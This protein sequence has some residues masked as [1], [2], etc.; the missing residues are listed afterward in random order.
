MVE[1]ECKRCKKIFNKK[2]SYLT[3]FNRKIKCKIIKQEIHD[4]IIKLTEENNKINLENINLLEQNELLKIENN[5]LVEQNK[6][7]NKINQNNIFLIE[8]NNNL[9]KIMSNMQLL[10]NNDEL[11]NGGAIEGLQFEN[12]L[13]NKLKKYNVNVYFNK[14]ITK[15]YGKSCAGVNIIVKKDDK[16]I[17][18]Q[19]KKKIKSGSLKD[20]NHFIKGSQIIEKKENT[21]PN[22]YWISKVSPNKSALELLKLDN[23]TIITDINS[24]N[25]LKKCIDNIKKD[26]DLKDEILKK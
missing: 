14:E 11:Q 15:K 24:K 13:S 12:Q 1:Y 6:Q 2:S 10:V 19:C 25:C 23:I 8:Q 9:M 17:T 20:V 4:E 3:H 22:L 16:L 7:L 21:K 26:M 5:N 18:L